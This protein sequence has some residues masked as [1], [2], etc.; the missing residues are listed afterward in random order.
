MSKSK[1]LY[2]GY[3]KT[4]LPKI[5]IFPTNGIH[6]IVLQERGKFCLNTLRPIFP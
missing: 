4:E 2:E 1:K 6:W 5:F 3:Q